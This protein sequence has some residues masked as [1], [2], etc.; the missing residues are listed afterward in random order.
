[1]DANRDIVNSGHDLNAMDASRRSALT[2]ENLRT[3]VPRLDN[4][5]WLR[6]Q[7]L[8]EPQGNLYRFA[9]AT[10]LIYGTVNFDPNF[11]DQMF[12]PRV[13]QAF[14]NILSSPD[15][16][17]RNLS[18]PALLAPAIPLRSNDSATLQVTSSLFS[19]L[20][21]SSVGRD[22]VEFIPAVHSRLQAVSL[23]LSEG[24]HLSSIHALL[25]PFNKDTFSQF[26]K[27]AAFLSSNN[28]L[29]AAQCDKIVQWIIDNNN[30]SNLRAFFSQDMPTISAF[31]RSI[32]E[33]AIRIEDA[34]V[35]R[36]LLAFG[37]DPNPPT[38]MD[39]RTPLQLAVGRENIRLFEILLNAGA[40]VNALSTGMGGESA[41]HIA[42]W[43]S[44]EMVE[45][46]LSKG[47]HVDL[48][49]CI[50][51]SRT[52]LQAAAEQGQT[53]LVA[54]LLG[55]GADV[56]AAAATSL[57]ATNQSTG[58][59]ALQ[60]VATYYKY[61][62]W[63]LELVQYLVDAGAD[64]NAPPY[65]N[66]DQYDRHI[67][68]EPDT[69]YGI[70]ALQGAARKGRVDVVQMLLGVGADVNAPAAAG[71]YGGK[72]ALQEAAASGRTEVVKL[73]LTAGADLNAP[74]ASNRS[75]GRTALQA[76]TE[77]GNVELIQILLNW[78]ADV[79]APGCSALPFASKSKKGVQ[80]V[81]IL[82]AAG[83]DVNAE[84]AG[85]TALHAAIETGSVEIVQMLLKAD[86]DVNAFGGLVLSLA[87]ESKFRLELVPILLNAGADATT[88]HGSVA[89]VSAAELGSVYL[90]E[91][92][93]AAG[94]D[95]NSKALEAAMSKGHDDVVEVLRNA[96][97]CFNAYQSEY[98]NTYLSRAVLQGDINLVHKLLAAGA[99]VNEYYSIDT[100]P[101]DKW[102]A[103]PLP[104]AVECGE[105]EMVQILLDAG[106]VIDASAIDLGRYDEDAEE[107][108]EEP[109]IDNL[110]KTALLTAVLKDK[111][112][113]VN[114]LINVGANVNARPQPFGGW[115]VLQAATKK[116]NIELVRILLSVGAEVNA[117]PHADRGR[118]ALQAAA[119]EGHIELVRLLLN[120]GADVNA[121]A[122]ESRG[123]TA[124]QGAAIQ[125]QLGIALMLLKAGAN[126]N[127]PAAKFDGRTALE[128]AAEQGRLDMVQLLFNVGADRV[129]SDGKIAERARDLALKNGHAVVAKEFELGQ[130]R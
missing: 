53:E 40:D 100:G 14:G 123:V 90:V 24:E 52:A 61:A 26:L 54:F 23:E 55:A 3:Y 9:H 50:H 77:N 101:D 128:G 71:P 109:D 62:D 113:L 105:I 73:L 39:G 36:I 75:T 81:S 2:P 66:P 48:P 74:V 31:A 120:A 43:C 17:P 4:L 88:E 20:V 85:R 117:E 82:L 12:N 29:D 94:A 21:P 78:G 83:A 25:G 104:L 69:E 65:W 107:Y 15:T 37:V 98:G 106:A 122:A 108:A 97:A 124:L 80:L 67:A 125:G 89:L 86:A 35:V 22:S 45:Q 46:L 68:E 114:M 30:H 63:G 59:T 58:S 103:N 41:L 6:F 87:T 111:D 28:M 60:T 116:G 91:L 7:R 16:A 13:H 47:A 18:I 42:V 93:L 130:F 56:N 84:S 11:V 115:T 19:G 127:A 57:T 72:T 44:I 126:P 51:R 96:G 27:Y 49:G 112:E 33:S 10:K 92:L 5:P 129:G 110:G 64:V 1:M 95:V 76:A 70:T 38:R 99:R 34:E 8:F 79:N 121:P 102:V 32:F 118:T 119:T